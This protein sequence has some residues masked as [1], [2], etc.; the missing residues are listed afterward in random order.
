MSSSPSPPLRRPLYPVLVPSYIDLTQI[1]QCIYDEE[2][3]DFTH[4]Q[5]TNDDDGDS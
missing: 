1:N 5:T 2:F 4:V 3:C